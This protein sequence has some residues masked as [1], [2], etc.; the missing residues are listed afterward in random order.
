MY[1]DVNAAQ[2]LQEQ[3]FDSAFKITAL[4][5]NQFVKELGPL[6]G[7]QGD[8][9]AEKIHSRAENKKNQVMHTWAAAQNITSLHFKAMRVNSINSGVNAFFERMPSYQDIFGRLDYCQCEHCKS[10]FGP[11]AY[12]IVVSPTVSKYTLWNGHSKDER[13][14]AIATA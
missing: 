13:R 10:I 4:S 11:P 9:K 12:V 3:G 8:A 5:R 14:L 1:P 6:L 2:T 7:E